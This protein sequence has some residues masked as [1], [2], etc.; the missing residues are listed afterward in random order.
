MNCTGHQYEAPYGM[1]TQWRCIQFL[2]RGG[3]GFRPVET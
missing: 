1:M 2:G 3:G